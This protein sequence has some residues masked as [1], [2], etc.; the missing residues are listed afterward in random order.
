MVRPHRPLQRIFPKSEGESSSTTRPR[1][2]GIRLAKPGVMTPTIAVYA[3]P[4]NCRWIARGSEHH[5]G[6]WNYAICV[7]R[8]TDQVVNESDCSHCARW[9]EPDD[10]R[11]SVNQRL[12]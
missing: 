7:R 3:S 6:D 11:E 1:V 9:Q 12:E 5:V 4:F 10:L 2:D 8:D